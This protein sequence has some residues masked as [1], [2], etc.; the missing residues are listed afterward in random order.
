LLSSADGVKATGGDTLGDKGRFDRLRPTF[1]QSLLIAVFVKR[2]PRAANDGTD[3]GTEH[4]VIAMFV[5]IPTRDSTDAR[6]D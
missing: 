4:G 2:H 6:A 3:T 5:V 1:G